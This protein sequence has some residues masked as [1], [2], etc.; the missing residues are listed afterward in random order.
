MPNKVMRTLGYLTF[1]ADGRTLTRVAS[2]TELEEGHDA[3]QRPGAPMQTRPENPAKWFDPQF[4]DRFFRYY[5]VELPPDTPPKEAQRFSQ[6]GT[7]LLFNIIVALEWTPSENDQARLEIA[8]RRASNFLYDISEG[9]MAFG[10]VVIGGPSIM[11]H[12]DIQIFSSNVLYPRAGLKKVGSENNLRVLP[13]R[14]GRRFF[15]RRLGRSID[16]EWSEGYRLL[17]H[18]WAHYALGLTDRYLQKRGEGRNAVVIP[19]VDPDDPSIMAHL[20]GH[21]LQG[22]ESFLETLLDEIKAGRRVGPGELPFNLPQVHFLPPSSHPSARC[23]IV[24][25]A[26]LPAERYGAAELYL[27]KQ[28]STT[29]DAATGLVAWGTLDSLIVE[30]GA[31]E[32]GDD[33]RIEIPDVAEADTLLLVHRQAGGHVQIW[34]AA[35]HRLNGQRLVEQWESATPNAIPHLAAVP[36]REPRHAGEVYHDDEDYA[37]RVVVDGKRPEGATLWLFERGK[38]RAHDVTKQPSG[39]LTILDGHIVVIWPDKK[40]WITPFSQG[41][42]GP[43]DNGANGAPPTTA[44]SSDGMATI[45]FASCKGAVTVQTRS[46]VGPLV[47]LSDHE[48]AYLRIL[49]TRN[50][51]QD[52]QGDDPIYTLA[53]SD[54]FPTTDDVNATLVLYHRL[55][56]RADDGSQRMTP[57]IWRDDE[58]IAPHYVDP[59][60]QYVALRLTEA[61][62]PALFSVGGPR[63]ESYQLRWGGHE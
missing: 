11:A 27:L 60:S 41:G 10:Q 33:V 54:P 50:L 38:H 5:K 16:W 53:A 7:L 32:R 52:G 58:A 31:R 12:A 42:V 57:T 22:E 9:Y 6:G 34:S 39:E 15:H 43:G 63:V 21:T 14:L 23:R 28:D 26:D 24:P 18:E 8:V 30:G 17:I 55:R 40:Y 25:P 37:Y 56:H 61:T 59:H 36:L 51:A 62:A 49:T 29:P 47:Q 13:V 1:D 44:G 46:A 45:F 48:A 2:L 19:M 35:S 4:A 20:L 3:G